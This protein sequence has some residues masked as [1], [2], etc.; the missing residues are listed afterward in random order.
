ME[1]NTKNGKHRKGWEGG[2]D[3]FQVEQ[4]QSC[5]A[6][7]KAHTRKGS[8][9]IPAKGL[10][11]HLDRIPRNPPLHKK[12]KEAE[13]ERKVRQVKFLLNLQLINKDA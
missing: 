1:P 11:T 9:V 6:N 4:Q 13:G 2:V 12:P 7:D 10:Y 3:S 8:I 5:P